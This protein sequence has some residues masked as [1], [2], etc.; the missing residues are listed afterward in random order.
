MASIIDKLHEWGCDT[1]KA[2]ERLAGDE[3]LYVTCL[4]MLAE[5]EGFERL[6]VSLAKGDVKGSFEA[7]HSLKGVIANLALTPLYEV[8]SSIV[9]ELRAGNILRAES[10]WT[11][12]QETKQYF[13]NILQQG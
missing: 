11:T 7:A 12:L 6:R 8:I 2:K 3:A 1:A 4:Q 9:E 13:V 5:D 10:Q